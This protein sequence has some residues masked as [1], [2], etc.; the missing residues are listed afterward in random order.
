MPLKLREEEPFTILV[1]KGKEREHS[2]DLDLGG[3]IILKSILEQ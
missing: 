3:K 2:L 1:G